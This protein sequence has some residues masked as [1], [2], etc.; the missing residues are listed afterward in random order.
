MSK[1]KVTAPIIM[2]GK[3]T[4]GQKEIKFKQ[5]KMYKFSHLGALGTVFFPSG[6]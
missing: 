5:G 4:A 3:L 6:H 2:S 1:A